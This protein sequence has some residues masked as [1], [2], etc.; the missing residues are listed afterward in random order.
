MS[1]TTGTV[2]GQAHPFPMSVI[3]SGKTEMLKF[4]RGQQC[5]L[6]SRR[7]GSCGGCCSV[8]REHPVPMPAQHH[9]HS[10]AELQRHH[11]STGGFSLLSKNC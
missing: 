9:K 5:Y 1:G 6:V 3:M 7:E 11:Y 8:Q 2:P 4:K 10:T